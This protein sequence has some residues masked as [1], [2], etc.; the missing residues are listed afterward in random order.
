MG[1]HLMTNLKQDPWSPWPRK[2]STD[3]GG[4]DRAIPCKSIIAGVVWVAAEQRR[5]ER[6]QE[7]HKGE[8]RVS[9]LHGQLWI[10][11]ESPLRRG[12]PGPITNLA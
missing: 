8:L 6:E 11:P 9:E 7:R 10:T 3:S 5:P 12:K 4:E 1:Q 2:L